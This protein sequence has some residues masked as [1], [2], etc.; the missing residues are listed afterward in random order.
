[1]S[2]QAIDKLH[3]LGSIYLDKASFKLL[4]NLILTFNETEE[5]DAIDFLSLASKRNV[6][7]IIRAKNYVGV[8]QLNN[9]V[10][11]QILPKV[12]GGTQNDAK[13]TFL[14]M[15]KTLRNFPSKTFN[16]ANLNTKKMDL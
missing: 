7:K 15:L 6:G 13:N 12:H 16:E 2:S 4:E 14:K 11:L 10:Q 8:I 9:G 1:M 3:K 5:A